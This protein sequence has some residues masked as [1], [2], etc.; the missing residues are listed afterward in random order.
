MV[1]DRFTMIGEVLVKP[2]DNELFELA[3][4]VSVKAHSA[5]FG[6]LTIHLKKGFIFD[7]GSVPRLV[8]KWFPYIGNQYLALCYAIHDLL[9]STQSYLHSFSKETVD[10]LLHEMILKL[11]TGIGEW[12]AS[13]IY[14]AVDICG[15]KAW[16]EFDDFDKLAIK[17]NLLTTS[18]SKK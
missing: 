11:P 9:Y 18:W 13:C 3:E 1:F 16:N 17:N 4:D 15:S 7:F 10:D 2:Y 12:K 6:V 14:Y 8:R 5:T